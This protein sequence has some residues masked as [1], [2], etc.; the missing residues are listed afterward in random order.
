[1]GLVN[2]LLRWQAHTRTDLE[3]F[4]LQDALDGGIFTAR[5]QLGLEDDAERAVAHDLALCVREVLVLARLAVLD[6]LADDFCARVRQW[7]RSGGR[8]TYRPF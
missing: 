2:G 6:L 1:M 8:S 4:V 7:Q 3:A 5:R